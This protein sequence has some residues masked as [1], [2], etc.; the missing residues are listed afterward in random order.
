M[1]VTIPSTPKHQGFEWHLITIEIPDE[2]PQCGGPRGKTYRTHSY[3]GSRRL[4]CD[5]WKNPCGHV[6]KYADVVV[7][8]GADYPN[9]ITLRI[10]RSLTVADC[11]Y[12]YGRAKELL[13]PG[14]ALDVEFVE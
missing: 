11:S 7:E 2:C 12:W 3:D 4:T 13:L 9:E 10:P 1:K 14:Q 8:A 6:D 5:G